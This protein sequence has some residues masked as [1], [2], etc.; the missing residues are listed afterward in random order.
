MSRYR[1][2]RGPELPSVCPLIQTCEKQKRD[3]TEYTALQRKWSKHD[4]PVAGVQVYFLEAYK[5]LAEDMDKKTREEMIAK[6]RPQVSERIN[7][8]CPHLR[9][10]LQHL[11]TQLYMNCPIFSQW[12]WSQKK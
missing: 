7:A 1:V 6:L 11:S 8:L 10:E 12:Y 4:E 5:G 9:A 3:L 2:E